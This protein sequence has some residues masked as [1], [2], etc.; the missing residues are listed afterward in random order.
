MSY[1]FIF[2]KFQ[3]LDFS[4]FDRTK[5]VFEEECS[6]KN[7]PVTKLEAPALGS[8]KLHLVQVGHP[9]LQ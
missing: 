7:K 5:T 6:E 9:D 1:P 2:T 4:G 8:E 3:Y